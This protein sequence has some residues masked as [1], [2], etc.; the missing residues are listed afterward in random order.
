MG[1]RRRRRRSG[2]ICPV[3]YRREGKH[4]FTIKG[5]NWRKEGDAATIMVKSM[6]VS[7]HNAR[8]RAEVPFL[9]FAAP[10]ERHVMR[11][12]VGL[13][14]PLFQTDGEWSPLLV[15]WF[16]TKGTERASVVVEEEDD[17][18]DFPAFRQLLEAHRPQQEEER[19]GGGERRSS[20]VVH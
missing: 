19:R 6:C 14:S 17:D 7:Q 10:T 3:R 13:F 9:F 8:S 12:R 2:S 4:T 15:R 20:K 11:R 1:R 16:G 5:K 18:E